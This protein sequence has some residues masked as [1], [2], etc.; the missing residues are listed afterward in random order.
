[1]APTSLLT[2][3]LAGLS[4]AL[5]SPTSRSK[6]LPIVFPEDTPVCQEGLICRDITLCPAA[7]AQ[8]RSGSRPF[9]CGWN[10]HVAKVCCPK[11]SRPGEEGPFPSGFIAFRRP[12]ECGILVIP[13][14]NASARATT[15]NQSTPLKTAASGQFPRPTY[16]SKRPGVVANSA[17]PQ[18]FSYNSQA[19]TTQDSRQGV[20]FPQSAKTYPTLRPS[21]NYVYNPGQHTTRSYWT[22]TRSPAP[23][24][25]TQPTKGRYPHQYQHQHPGQTQTQHQRPQQ[26]YQQQQSSAQ[27][28]Y[29]QPQQPPQQQQQHVQ[30]SVYQNNQVVNSH[31]QFEY[32]EYNSGG[33]PSYIYGRRQGSHYDED[34]NPTTTPDPDSWYNYKTFSK[35]QARDLQDRRP[36]RTGKGGKGFK[37]LEELEGGSKSIWSS[38]SKEEAAQSGLSDDVIAELKAKLLRGRP[39]AG[40]VLRNEVAWAAKTQRSK[41]PRWRTLTTQ[42]PRRTKRTGKVDAR[43]PDPELIKA[44]APAVSLA[45]GGQ[46]DYN[47]WP[48]MAAILTG[49]ELK[50]L[51]GGFLINDRYVISAAHCFQR[52]RAS[53]TFGVRLGQIRVDEGRVYRVE[54]YVVHED[55]VRREYYNDIA[56]LRLA[57]PVPLALIKPVCL[58]GP[59]LASSDLVGREATVLGWGD[60]M[61]GGP[62][63]DILQE[64]NGLPVVPVKQCNE[65]YS[66]LRGNPF[67][68]G[69]TPEFV[70]AG[71][72]QGG[73]DACQGDS[74]GPLMLDN[75][76]RWTAVGIV[77][78]GYRCGVAGYPGVYTRVSKHLQW[79]DNNLYMDSV[80]YNTIV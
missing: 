76:G 61:F 67:R 6:Y 70:C 32:F 11:D 54:R 48:W 43:V 62:R 52:P 14:V 79:I 41:K 10:R 51:C 53:Q 24:P 39:A 4:Q 27:Q 50:F 71:L 49:S 58:P 1:M 20:Q 56:L 31:H 46:A 74:G 38:A 40:G 25:Q 37:D 77:S 64:V 66:K 21:V 16:S 13:Q 12:A 5:A 9:I 34:P 80:G 78:F 26:G 35:R 69:I 75:E 42:H 59:S 63:S 19:H 72:P 47:T 44:L 29:Q 68:R 18:G 36:R 8:V 60:T 2:F 30:Y 15:A 23:A 33:S 17:A 65:S 22:T 57:E 3:L 28:G 45:V 73:K 55:Y 7:I